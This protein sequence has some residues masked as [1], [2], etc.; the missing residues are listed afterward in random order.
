MSANRKAEKLP[1]IE[2]EYT[3]PERG[4][5]ARKGGTAVPRLARLL[6][7]AIRLQELVDAGEATSYAALERVA[8]VSRSRVSQIMSLL[9]LAPDIQESILFWKHPPPREDEIRKIARQADWAKQR[10]LWFELAQAQERS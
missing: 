4:K 5:R 2:L 3:L 7:L 8:G 1:S 6:A 9:N 10:Q